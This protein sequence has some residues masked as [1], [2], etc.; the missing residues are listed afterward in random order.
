MLIL[1]E[2]EK[3]V[4]IDSINTPLPSE[5]F[6]VLDLAMRDFTLTP[7]LVLE[8]VSCPTLTLEVEGVQLDVPANWNI[9]IYDGTTGD[10]D[11]VPVSWVGHKDFTAFAYGPTKTIPRPAHLRLVDYKPYST[12]VAPALNKH[13]MLCHPIGPSL[14]INLSPNDGY[15]KYLKNTSMG[16]L[17]E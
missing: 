17:I 7:L 12:T 2:K 14:W 1:D 6:W 4:V 11:I 15:A 5:Y 10:I 3:T 8:E 9:L 16:D 13:Q